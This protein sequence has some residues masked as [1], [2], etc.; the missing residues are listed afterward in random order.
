MKLYKVQVLCEGLKPAYPGKKKQDRLER[1]Y[2]TVL[3][4]ATDASTAME[5]G[6]A[7]ADANA[8]PDIQWKLFTPLSA[9][10]FVLPMAVEDLR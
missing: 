3:V 8:A 6:R 1:R 4:Q 2:T 9:A 10:C 7:Y 5:A